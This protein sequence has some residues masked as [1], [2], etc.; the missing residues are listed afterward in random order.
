LTTCSP[1]PVLLIRSILSGSVLGC[2]GAIYGIVPWEGAVRVR[3]A[4]LLGVVLRQALRLTHSR[5]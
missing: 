4:R 5:P 1:P 3:E 2:S